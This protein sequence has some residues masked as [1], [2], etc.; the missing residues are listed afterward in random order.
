MPQPVSATLMR[1]PADSG[2]RGLTPEFVST[3]IVAPL[4][5]ASRLFAS[6]LER[7]WRNSPEI[8]S[9]SISVLVLT[10]K[11]TPCGGAR[12]DKKLVT[13]RTIVDGLK[14]AGPEVSR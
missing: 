13:S 12:G 10:T 9:T 3:R 11:V 6:R 1:T 14:W 8:P 7:I 2:L 4:E 5:Q